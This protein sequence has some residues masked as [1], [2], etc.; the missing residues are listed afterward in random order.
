MRLLN[1]NVFTSFRIKSLVVVL[2][3]MFLVAVSNAYSSNNI[4]QNVIDQM[5]RDSEQRLRDQRAIQ[6]ALLP[7]SI[8]KQTFDSIAPKKTNIAKG[9]PCFW[10]KK[11]QLIDDSNLL[12]T[13]LDFQ[14]LNN[15]CADKKAL[16]ELVER[17]NV[18]YQQKGLITTR[19][20]LKPQNLKSGNL[21]LVAKAG[22]LQDFSF[23][24]GKEVDRR[25]H[26]AYP[27][28]KGE[29]ISLREMEQ[30]LDNL[31][32]LKSQSAKAQLQPGKQLGDSILDITIKNEK[33]WRANFGLNNYGVASTGK[34]NG[35]FG[36]ELD[37]LFNANDDLSLGYNQNTDA[38]SAR[39]RNRSV[40]MNY[41]IPYKNWLFQ[42][43]TSRYKYKRIIQ[44]V[45]QE[46]QIN[47]HNRN[48]R[49]G[50]EK[51]ISRDQ[52]SRIYLTTSLNLKKSRNYIEGIEI[53][54]QYR[55]LTL[56]EVGF[57][58]DHQFANQNFIDWTISAGRN[59]KGLT[60]MHT[61]PGFADDDFAY[62]R[63][64][65]KLD[66]PINNRKFLYSTQAFFQYSENEL[67]G[68]EQFSAGGMSSVRGFHNASIYGNSGLYWR[69]NFSTA[70]RNISGWKLKPTLS[71]DIGAVKSPKSITW[72]KPFVAGIAASITAKYND[73]LSLKFDV[74]RAVN[75]PTQLVGDKNHAFFSINYAF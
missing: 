7:Q 36:F 9:G 44:G 61:I 69:N 53:E 51:L 16:V 14:K 63:G 19:V 42:L 33:P 48:R 31:N 30:G 56:F 59:Y 10:I 4:S 45:N 58:G 40:S 65:F 37:N 72:S 3:T 23:S 21:V 68:S 20:Y 8:Q 41:N 55:E 75:R 29:L 12:P 1:K 35:S 47:G 22:L 54:S 73:K 50:V 13:P 70:E 62:L 25:V 6:D 66:V 32:R 28:K 57:R 39:K 64:G 38:N 24:D 71:F 2:P 5:A 49:I 52:Q 74:S 34:K 43:S 26:N 15:T 27:F 67:T 17:L 60:D 46:Y 18:Y 11:T